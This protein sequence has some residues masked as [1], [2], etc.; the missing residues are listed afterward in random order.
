[1]MSVYPLLVSSLTQHA[2]P[3]LGHLRSFVIM[4]DNRLVLCHSDWCTLV[5]ML[6]I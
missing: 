5:S 4:V 3:I 1:M 6:F 2:W